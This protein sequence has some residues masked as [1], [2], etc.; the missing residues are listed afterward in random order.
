[1][2]VIK[3]IDNFALK[4]KKNEKICSI[5]KKIKYKIFSKIQKFNYNLKY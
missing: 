3:N 2:I 1:V 4:N 5:N